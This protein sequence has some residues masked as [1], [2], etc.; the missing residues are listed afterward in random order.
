M[1]TKLSVGIS[2][3]PN[4]TYAFHGLLT[5][6]VETGELE[7]EFTLADVE[8]LNRGLLAG[9]YDVCKVSFPAAL[10]LTGELSVLPAGAALGFGVGPVV[11]GRA[12]SPTDDTA[13]VLCP[14]AHTT[15]ALL[16]RLFHP[17]GRA[18]EHVVFSEILPAVAAGRA[19]LGVCI[20]EGRFT[21]EGLGLSLVEDLGETWERATG[22]ALPLGG[23]V[24]RKRLGRATI[25]RAASLLRA[26]IA[27]ADAHPE[28]ALATM[29]RHAREHDDAALWKHVELYVND[30]TRALSSAGRAALEEL[31]SRARA[32]GLPGGARGLEVAGFD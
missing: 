10:E 22:A 15:A 25:E 11:V 12:D 4:D 23:I 30:E 17:R 6:A 3:C 7:L 13:R 32:A 24:A 1:S 18:P 21:Y 29:R 2:T 5:G 14:G 28:E 8:E 9:R 20:H 31:C 19:D 16:W 27:H 26:S